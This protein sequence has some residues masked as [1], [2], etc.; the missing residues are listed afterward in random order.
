MFCIPSPTKYPRSTCVA[1]LL[2][3]ITPRTAA[4]HANHLHPPLPPPPLYLLH[5][6]PLLKM[7]A[8]VKERTQRV[9]QERSKWTRRKEL[10]NPR[11][12]KK[13]W[14]VCV[15][16]WVTRTEEWQEER[17][18]HDVKVDRKEGS[19]Q[20]KVEDYRVG[21][22]IEWTTVLFKV[23]DWGGGGSTDSILLREIMEICKTKR[24]QKNW[25]LICRVLVRWEL[26]D[27]GWK[28]MAWGQGRGIVWLKVEEDRVE[29]VHAHILG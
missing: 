4:T 25:L 28:K 1:V 11:W 5:R 20:F 22:G 2:T 16:G 14:G 3:D 7:G 13:R 21:S 23:E 18:E 9:R 8:R 26:C 15:F 29:G 24:K 17:K 6:H 19:E 12:K 10:C 27:S